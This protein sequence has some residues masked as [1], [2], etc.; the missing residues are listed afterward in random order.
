M[1]I[2]DVLG[3][4]LTPDRDYLPQ[5][6]A[7]HIGP[8]VLYDTAYEQAIGRPSRSLPAL[9][10]LRPQPMGWPLCRATHITDS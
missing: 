8:R 4:L 7:L 2:T 6:G 3:H 10:V 1:P 5:H 9:K